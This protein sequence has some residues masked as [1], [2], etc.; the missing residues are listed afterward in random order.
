MMLA[1]LQR[2]LVWLVVIW[3]GIF[4]YLLVI[5]VIRYFVSFPIPSFFAPLIDNPLR[6]RIQ[7][8]GKVVTWMDIQKGMRVLEIGPGNGTFTFEAA[9]RAGKGQVFVMD[10]QEKVISN[11]KGTLYTHN[12][13]PL[14][15]S[16]H[17]LPF[18]SGVFDRVFMVTVL[19]EIPDKVKALNEIK[20]VLK[21]DGLL[22]VGEF[23]P[24]PDYPR[25]KTVITWCRSCGFELYKEHGGI[26]HYL[27]TF[28]KAQ[29]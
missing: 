23:L 5:R 3:G 13:I 28:T 9:S 24:D 27:V 18:S 16:A 20:R 29:K 21:D 7:P 10:I 15:A 19:P 26:L 4:L 14:V 12:V 17:E 1:L 22:A 25:R 8:P 11:L 2:I 6:R